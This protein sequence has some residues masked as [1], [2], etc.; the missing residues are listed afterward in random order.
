MNPADLPFV[1]QIRDWGPDDRV[2]DT[3]LLLGPIVVV[4]IATAGRNLVTE[5]VAVAYIAAFVGYVCSKALRDR[6]RR[7]RGGK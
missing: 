4:L 3:L 7:N 5:A 6:K 1:R 2:F